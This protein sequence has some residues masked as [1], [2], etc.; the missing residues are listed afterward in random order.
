MF[1]EA[2]FVLTVLGISQ[3][4]LDCSSSEDGQLRLQGGTEYA[5]RVE[6][7]TRDRRGDLQEHHW[8]TVCAIGLDML[9]AT[10]ICHRL[11]YTNSSFTGKKLHVYFRI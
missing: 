4:Q 1:L 11:N 8:L 7:C 3:Q 5:G 9:Q 6:Y 10:A 2:I